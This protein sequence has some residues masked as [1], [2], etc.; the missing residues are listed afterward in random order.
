M[1]QNPYA[2]KVPKKSSI[3]GLPTLPLPT[4][5]PTIPDYAQSTERVMETAVKFFNTFQKENF[6]GPSLDHMINNE[7]LNMEY[8]LSTFSFSLLQQ[9]PQKPQR[10]EGKQRYASGTILTYVSKVK[11]I[12]R[13]QNMNNWCWRDERWYTSLTKNI[14]KHCERVK[15]KEGSSNLDSTFP[16]YRKTDPLIVGTIKQYPDL[17]S[18]I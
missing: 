5:L 16:V 12:L 18:I 6:N 15:I 8:V 7:D 17:N 11:G 9:Q 1:Q 3:D 2:K 13:E 14:E 10:K 4:L